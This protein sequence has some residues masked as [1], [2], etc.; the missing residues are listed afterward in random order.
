MT[1]E[2]TAVHTPMVQRPQPHII[3]LQDVFYFKK[4][5]TLSFGMDFKVPK[6]I[7]ENMAAG[8]PMEQRSGSQ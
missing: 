3:I 8:V 1:E 7:A 4:K 2:D 6:T 5:N